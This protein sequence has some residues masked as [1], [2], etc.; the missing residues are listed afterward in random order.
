MTIHLCVNNA[1]I[2]LSTPDLSAQILTQT[3]KD[4]IMD[5]SSTNCFKMNSSSSSC[6][7]I[8]SFTLLSYQG[9]IFDVSLFI[10]L[11]ST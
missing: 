10:H 1:P 8:S 11:T 6:Q 3:F 5:V 2:S 4:L 7:C 9:A